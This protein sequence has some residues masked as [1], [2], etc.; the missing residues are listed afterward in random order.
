MRSSKEWRSFAL[1]GALAGAA[2]LRIAFVDDDGSAIIGLVLLLATFA[3]A[4][5]SGALYSQRLRTLGRDSRLG[6]LNSIR[7]AEQPPS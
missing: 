5:A 7:D 2:L 1:L 3:L 6:L 4:F